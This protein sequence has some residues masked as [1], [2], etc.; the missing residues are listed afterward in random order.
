MCTHLHRRSH[1]DTR[2]RVTLVS[3]LPRKSP[4]PQFR[5]ATYQEGN[6]AGMKL[7]KSILTGKKQ[8][9]FM[10]TRGKSSPTCAREPSFHHQAVGFL[11]PP[12]GDSSAHILSAR[13]GWQ[14]A[15]ESASAEQPLCEGAKLHKIQ[16]SVNKDRLKVLTH[17]PSAY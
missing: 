1:L 14:R 5:P 11:A 6:P 15:Q 8:E 9:F 7:D 4:P 13:R 12:C 2:Q 10:L 17:S 16:F 3:V